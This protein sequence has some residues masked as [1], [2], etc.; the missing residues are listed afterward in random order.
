M[1]FHCWFGG[2]DEYMRRMWA[3]A[4]YAPT[5]VKLITPVD[6]ASFRN[7]ATVTLKAAASDRDGTIAKVE[8]FQ[9]T[10]RDGRKKIGEATTAPYT[11]NW[12]NAPNGTYVVYAHAIDNKGLSGW[13]PMLTITIGT[14][15]LAP[16]K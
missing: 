6:K 5:D 9:A 13:S 2:E 10:T 11:C 4:G 7:N 16:A 15:I 1:M 3:E 8:F 12:K 14:G